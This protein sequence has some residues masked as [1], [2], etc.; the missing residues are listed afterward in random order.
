MLLVMAQTTS[1]SSA[2]AEQKRW[3]SDYWPQ[4]VAV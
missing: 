3:R 1:S 4:T 2:F